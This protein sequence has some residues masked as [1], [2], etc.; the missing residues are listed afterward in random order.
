MQLRFRSGFAVALVLWTTGCTVGPNY[1]RPDA[2]VPDQFKET[3]PSAAAA[4]K[5]AIGYPDWWHVFQDSA[6]DQLEAQVESANLDI[7]AAVA[8][9]DQAQAGTKYARSF[10]SPT[11]SLGAGASRNREAQIAIALAGSPQHI[12]TFLSPCC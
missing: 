1:K 10:L 9:F 8:R 4:Q 11:L 2:P 5:P 12:T 7:R 6:L 3:G